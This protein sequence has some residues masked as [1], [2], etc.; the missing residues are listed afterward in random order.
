MIPLIIIITSAIPRVISNCWQ[1]LFNRF[2]SIG[3]SILLFILCI[4]REYVCIVFPLAYAAVAAASCSSFLSACLI[5]F[6]I[7]IIIFE[8]F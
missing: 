6:I 5:V 4:F 2:L 8:L 3:Y 7:I 1:F